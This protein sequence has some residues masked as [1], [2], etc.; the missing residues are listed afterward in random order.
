MVIE[1]VHAPRR[2]MW[3]PPSGRRP[4]KG[5]STHIHPRLRLV[6]AVRRHPASA[7]LA[8]AGRPA[9]AAFR[10]TKIA[11]NEDARNAATRLKIYGAKSSLALSRRP[12]GNL[13]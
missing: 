4:L 9:A 7:T 5:T 2:R 13:A 1:Y 11:G 8:R 10:A 12:F 3:K 6:R